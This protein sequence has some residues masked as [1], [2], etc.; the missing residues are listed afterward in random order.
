MQARNTAGA[1][2]SITEV[3]IG[4]T[5]FKGDFEPS[6]QLYRF[7]ISVYLQEILRGKRLNNGVRIMLKN[8][9]ASP[10]IFSLLGSDQATLN[11]TL[12]RE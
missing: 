3:S 2:T 11:L 1:W 5:Y 6:G 7:N 9:G 12:S 10:E 8:P 4:S